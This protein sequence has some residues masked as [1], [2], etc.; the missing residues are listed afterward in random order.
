MHEQALSS[1][2]SLHQ[3]IIG[4]Y[5]CGHSLTVAMGDARIRLVTNST[6]LVA[7][8]RDYFDGFLSGDTSDADCVIHAIEGKT[9]LFDPF[10]FTIKEPDPGKTKIK[11]EFVDLPD[12]RIVRKRLTGMVFLLGD[13]TH[14]AIGPCVENYNQVVNFINNRYIQYMLRRKCLLFHAAG[15]SV[16]GNGIML[17]GFSGK[18]K[19]TLAMHLVSSGVDFVSNDRMLFDRNNGEPVMYGVAKLPRINPGTIINNPDLHPIIPD[20]KQN[21]YAELEPHELWYLEEKYDAHINELFG[22]GRFKLSSRVRALVILNWDRDAQ[23]M[24]FTKIDLANRPD[25]FPAFMKSPG[26]FYLPDRLQPAPEY[27]EKTYS[28]YLSECDIYEVTGC[29]DF[30]AATECCND[31]M[32]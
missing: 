16:D 26:L 22:R 15:V 19:S 10:T 4:Q 23:G 6:E 31:L 8:L 30:D 9:D 18:G 7:V 21:E 14:C 28:E 1:V 24:S 13:E 32:Q 5:S 2:S 12:G 3:T 25:L 11:E 27:S 29:V 17:A 20:H